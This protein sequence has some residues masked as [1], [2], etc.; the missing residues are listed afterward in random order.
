MFI[1][2]DE[3][4]GHSR[5]WIYQA[6]RA[7]TQ[8]EQETVSTSLHAFCSGWAAHG[9]QLLTSYCLAHRHFIILAADEAAAGAS[10]CSID[11]SVRHL[12]ALGAQLGV[13]FFNRTLIPFLFGDD[14]HLISISSLKEGFSSGKL[15]ADTPTLN[16][17]A[18]TV[19]EFA[20]HWVI[21]AGQTWMSRYL[22]EAK[23]A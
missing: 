19:G 16:M 5:I 10:G 13:D 6:D 18:G 7:L 22:P 20:S 23:T 8:T 12:K 11:S 4:P 15:G 2:F 1:P 3:M 17:L 14:V 21:P 9:H